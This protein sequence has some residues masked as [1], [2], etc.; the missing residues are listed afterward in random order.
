MG[1]KPPPSRMLKTAMTK[2][3]HE[4]KNIGDHAAAKHPWRHHAIVATV[5]SALRPGR[6]QALHDAGQRLTFPRFARLEGDFRRQLTD[7]FKT[8][9]SDQE[10]SNRKVKKIFRIF[11]TQA[12]Q[13][14][15]AASKGGL[16]HHLPALKTEDKRW[17]ETFLRKEFDLWKKFMGE[18]RA[19]STT[20][21]VQPPR[22]R[23]NRGRWVL[24]PAIVTKVPADPKKM[25]YDQRKEMYIQALRSMYHSSRVIATPPMT[26]FYWMTN[27]AEHCVHCL[28]LQAKSPYIKENLPA[29]PAGGDTQC[30]SNCHCHLRMVQVTVAEYLRVKRKAPTRQKLLRGMR[31]LTR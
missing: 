29:V 28:Y 10:V 27:P 17:L 14:G 22:E 12:F 15:Q 4:A 8:I 20:K 25:D 18:V 24:P 13:L 21:T 9:S 3:L 19:A 26:L 23:D 1:T 16:S 5:K 11:Y 30:R 2:N 31:A 6:S 7:A